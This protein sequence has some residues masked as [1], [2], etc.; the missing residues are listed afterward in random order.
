MAEVSLD[1][2]GRSYVVTCKDGGEDQLRGL[3]RLVDEK[4]VQARAQMRGVNEVRQLLFASLFLADELADLRGGQ[5]PS[6]P[7][8][9][10]ADTVEQLA[11]RVEALADQLEESAPTP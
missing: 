3:A 11:I 4:A 9:E 7:D 8:P 10:L 6:A 1:I 2:G 5:K